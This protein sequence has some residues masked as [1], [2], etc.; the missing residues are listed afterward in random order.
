MTL[1]NDQKSE[2]KLTCRFKI[3]T[4]NLKNFDLRTQKSQKFTLQW[5]N[6]DQIICL[7]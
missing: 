4:R 3:N 2:K 1:K 7:S 6:F 5:A